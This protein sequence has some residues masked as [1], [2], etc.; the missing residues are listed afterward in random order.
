MDRKE[1]ILKQYELF[2]KE[3]PDCEHLEESFPTDWDGF[4]DSLLV[5]MYVESFCLKKKTPLTDPREELNGASIKNY[6]HINNKE[7]ERAE[8]INDIIKGAEHDNKN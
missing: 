2:Q 3:M 7:L 5:K 6:Y 4:V 8:E 1:R